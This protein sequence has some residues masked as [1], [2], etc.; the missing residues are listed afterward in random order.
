M[1]W[2]NPWGL[3]VLRCRLGPRFSGFCSSL[4]SFACCSLPSYL[5][6]LEILFMADPSNHQSTFGYLFQ[7]H[8]SLGRVPNPLRSFRIPARNDN[9]VI[10]LTTGLFF[11]IYTYITTS[12]SIQFIKIYSWSQWQAK[13]IY[14]LIGRG[15]T[16]SILFSGRLIDRAYCKAKAAQGS[17]VR[18]VMGDGLDTFPIERTRLIVMW[19]PLLISPTNWPHSIFPFD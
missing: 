13:L 17:T 15:G 19:I 18:N 4:E 10:L 3:S 6:F 12:L 1:P 2:S 11:V 9:A 14:L 8:A 16:V 7:S 5:R